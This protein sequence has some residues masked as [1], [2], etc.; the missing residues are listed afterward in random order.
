MNIRLKH[1]K[2]TV[3]PTLMLLLMSKYLRA[4]KFEVT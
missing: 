2:P 3:E 4:V 1:G